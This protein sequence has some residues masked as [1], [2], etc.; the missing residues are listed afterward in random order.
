M[1]YHM[2]ITPDRQCVALF[3]EWNLHASYTLSSEE[4]VRRFVFSDTW[5]H[6]TREQFCAV[7]DGRDPSGKPDPRLKT[8][9]KLGAPK[10]KLP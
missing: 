8:N 6:L 10:G 9:H 5:V 3:P 4:I 7:M 2:M 1:H